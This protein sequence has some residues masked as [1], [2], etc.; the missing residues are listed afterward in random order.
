MSYIVR[1][2]L[3][4]VLLT[5][6]VDDVNNPIGTI[7]L[8]LDEATTA[9]VKKQCDFLVRFWSEL[10][11][12]V[13]TRYLT[14]TFCART[15]ADELQKMVLNI[16]E[17]CEISIDKFANLST[18][19]PN[20]S[21]GLHR[22]LDQQLK[23]NI[24]HGLIPFNPCVLHKVHTGFHN[25]L[26]EY[27]KDMENLPFDLHGWFKIAPCKREDFVQVAVDFQN[28]ALFAV[29]ERNEALFYRH[30]ECRWLTLVPA[31]QK[32]EERWNQAKKYFLDFLPNA[33][34]FATTPQKNQRYIRIVDC[35]KNEKTIL[36]QLAFVIDVSTPFS[37][38]L[39]ELQSEGPKV[40][41]IYQSMKEMLLVL[42]RGFMKAD[43]LDGISG[44]VLQKV[45]VKKKENQLKLEDIEVGAKSKR[46]LG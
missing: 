33:K 4:E 6:L 41:T 42:M 28:E 17:S 18:D 8:L 46:L 39:L 34:N 12:Q 15:S 26:L 25:G 27:G 3:S 13:V 30:V 29:F 2:D 23:E 31:L 40:H 24:H 32:V 14:S 20:I 1:H 35:F 5:E 38:F 19:G 43:I 10:E 22:R 21:K 11:D 36:I 16:L 7:T 37:K 45:D 44:K 9:Q